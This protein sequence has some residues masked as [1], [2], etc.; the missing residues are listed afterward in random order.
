MLSLSN[1]NKKREAATLSNLIRHLA[2]ILLENSEDAIRNREAPLRIRLRLRRNNIIRIVTR[3]STC[4]ITRHTRRIMTMKYGRPSLYRA[5]DIRGIHLNVR[6]NFPIIIRTMI[7]PNVRTTER[8]ITMI[9]IRVHRMTTSTWQRIKISTHNMRRISTRHHT[10]R[11]IVTRKNRHQRIST[12][13]RTI[14]RL[15]RAH[16]RQHSPPTVHPTDRK[17]HN[18]VLSYD[19]TINKATHNAERHP[20]KRRPIRVHLIIIL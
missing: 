18:R 16:T 15:P 10:E 4:P 6:V 12:N 8:M 11:I 9:H 1:N 20:R 3:T 7:R 5:T 2:A 13:I 19:C 17:R 14:I